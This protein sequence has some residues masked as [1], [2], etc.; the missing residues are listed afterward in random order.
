MALHQDTK[1]LQSCVSITLPI[2]MGCRAGHCSLQHP[3]SIFLQGADPTVAL[4]PL[5]IQQ[6]GPAWLNNLILL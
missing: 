6:V 5:Y 1:S 2:L 4:P 3:P